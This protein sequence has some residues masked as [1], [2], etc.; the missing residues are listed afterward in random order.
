MPASE[1]QHNPRAFGL[2]MFLAGVVVFITLSISS[3]IKTSGSMMDFRHVFCSSR[4]LLENRD[5]YNPDNM[6][7]VYHKEGGERSSD[8]DND[9]ALITH[10][11]YL[12]TEFLVT[13][14][15]GFLPFEEAETLWIALTVALF[16]VAG[17][18]IWELG[19][20]YSPELVG[21]MLCFLF[22]N[23]EQVLLYGNPAGITVGLCVI[24]LWCFLREK[25]E[26][27][28][29][30][31]LAASIALKPHD[32]GF[33]WLYLF[34]ASGRLRRRALQSIAV[35]AAFSVPMLLW[36]QQVA[37]NWISELR[38]NWMTYSVRGGTNDP[39]PAGFTSHGT[40][41]I[42]DLQSVFSVLHD[43]PAF[44]NP[45]AYLTCA[46]LLTVWIIITLRRRPSLSGSLLA[47]ASIAPI[48]MLPTY[49]RIYDAKLVMLTVPACALLW[50]EGGRMKQIAFIVTAAGLVLS[51]DMPWSFFIGVLIQSNLLTP[52]Q[53]GP[54]MSAAL[55]F[56]L[57]LTLLIVGIFYLWVYALRPEQ[58]RSIRVSE[59]QSSP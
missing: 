24:A 53:P 30:L 29:V 15:L 17:Y 4:C 46:L 2:F 52:A 37:P 36:L 50:S 25:F 44:Y 55:G 14:P 13:I 59:P 18:L 34:L 10:Y 19:A 22:A 58:P 54:L 42:T 40:G 48:S 33:I 57:P 32:S 27:L 41:V 7:R 47:L 39:G 9:R 11:V 8:S 51:A 38:S 35:V 43:S 26:L 23:S 20:N 3:V 5:P 45:A 12:P 28:G 6:L 21:G 16:I 49:H 1:K 56:P 31:C